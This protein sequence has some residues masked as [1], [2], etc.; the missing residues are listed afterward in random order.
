MSFEFSESGQPFK[1]W[2]SVESDTHKIPSTVQA[3]SI[4]SNPLLEFCFSTWDDDPRVFFHH[5]LAQL[6]PSIWQYLTQTPVHFFGT[7]DT[8]K[9]VICLSLS[10]ALSLKVLWC[11]FHINLNIQ[12]SWP[13]WS[14]TYRWQF[15]TSNR[16]HGK[17]Q[18]N[19][20]VTPTLWAAVV[21]LCALLCRFHPPDSFAKPPPHFPRETPATP[22]A[23]DRLFLNVCSVDHMTRRPYRAALLL[24]A[25]F[26]RLILLRSLLLA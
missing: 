6:R 8:L 10:Q 4:F 16:F 7:R 26:I 21:S 3:C 24:P 25:C 19:P 14:S 15:S 22:I 9:K 17:D 20:K 23:L 13:L 5:I 12:N 18:T 11:H 2:R 1:Y